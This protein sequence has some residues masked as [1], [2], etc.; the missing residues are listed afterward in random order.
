MS[1]IVFTPPVNSQPPGTPLEKLGP[2]ADIRF[3]DV[4]NHLV[5][6]SGFS[7]SMTD[8]SG[9]VKAALETMD[10]LGVQKILVLPPP[11]PPNHRGQ[12][13]ADDFIE[14]IKK[15]PD[16]FGFL[17]GGGT[18]N[19]MIQQAAKEQTLSP[20][21]STRFEKEAENILAKGALGFGEITALHFS[22][23]IDHPFME[24]QPDHPL[25]LLL[26]DI[27]ARHDVPIDLHMEAVPEDMPLPD[28]PR[29]GSAKNPKTL[30]ANIP[31]FERLLDHNLKARIIWDHVGWCNTGRRT[32]ALCRALLSRHP[33]LYMSFK[34]GPDSNPECRPLAPGSGVKPEWIDLIRDFPD[35]FL[36]GMDQFYTAPGSNFRIGP[37]RN[38]P[39]KFLLSWLPRDLALK[40]ALENPKAVFKLAE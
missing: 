17:D 29:L 36:I 28:D 6:E 7:R 12:Y 32:P 5:G 20:G 14:A 37:Q 39:T 19:V 35:R 11:F 9:A 30:R 15:Y 40:V 31:A 3:I 24:V 4:H 16:R 25:F 10:K 2:N 1:L 18:L 27:A 26:A 22:L 38:N 33:N 8:F 21:L 34:I 13:T 23:S